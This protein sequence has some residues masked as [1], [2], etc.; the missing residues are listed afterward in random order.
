MKL[1]RI[2]VL[3]IVLAAAIMVPTIIVLTKTDINK[4]SFDDLLIKYQVAYSE[5]NKFSP[6]DAIS[7]GHVDPP[8]YYS[9]FSDD[10]IKM[11]VVLYD[12]VETP[13]QLALL[14]RYHLPV[15]PKSSEK[16]FRRVVSNDPILRIL[17]SYKSSKIERHNAFLLLGGIRM[18]NRS[19]LLAATNTEEAHSVVNKSYLSIIK[20]SRIMSGLFREGAWIELQK[21]MFDNPDLAKEV[22]IYLVQT[23]C[24]YIKSYEYEE[25]LSTARKFMPAKLVNCCTLDEMYMLLERYKSP[26]TKDELSIKTYSP[27]TPIDFVDCLIKAKYSKEKMLNLLRDPR[28]DLPAGVIQKIIDY[29]GLSPQRMVSLV[30]DEKTNRKYFDAASIYRNQYTLNQLL[31]LSEKGN[32]FCDRLDDINWRSLSTD[33]LIRYMSAGDWYSGFV[34]KI[35]SHLIKRKLTVAQLEK[36]GK[37]CPDKLIQCQN[38]IFLKT[39]G[40]SNY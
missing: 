7:N 5:A 15:C 6:L 23:T 13:K 9:D 21:R 3:L 32:Y 34:D 4:M 35:F 26:F 1:K 18:P 10:L 2:H 38:L 27:D 17:D 12:K 20:G 8:P 25:M 29:L 22:W 14:T 39:N 30:I 36:I 33:Q 11:A 24:V 16:A 37:C 31:D 40:C 19:V 28:N